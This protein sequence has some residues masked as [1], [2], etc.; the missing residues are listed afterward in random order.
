MCCEETYS[1]FDVE[2]SLMIKIDFMWK[3]FIAIFI[4]IEFF[5]YLDN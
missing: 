4:L 1:L 3:G 5:I 2:Y